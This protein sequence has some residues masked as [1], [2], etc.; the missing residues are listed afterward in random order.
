MTLLNSF[1]EKDIL[2]I[3]KLSGVK[4]LYIKFSGK[5]GGFAGSRTRSFIIKYGKYSRSSRTNRILFYQQQ[6]V[7]FN[8]AVGVNIAITYQ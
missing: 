6:L 2:G 3:F 5:L 7:N 4:G 1:E 8:G